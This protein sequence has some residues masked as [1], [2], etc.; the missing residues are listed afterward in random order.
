MNNP[1]KRA[2]WVFLIAL[3]GILFLISPGKAEAAIAVDAVS[4]GDTRPAT[5]TISHTMA[6][7]DIGSVPQGWT[8][9]ITNDRGYL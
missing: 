4:T 8:K 2:I 6:V 7:R 9:K 3:M 5:L 1:T